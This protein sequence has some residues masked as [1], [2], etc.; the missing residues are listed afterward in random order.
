[1]VPLVVYLFSRNARIRPRM[2]WWP[3]IPFSLYNHASKPTYTH[4]AKALRL[5]FLLT[6]LLLAGGSGTASVNACLSR[7][8]TLAGYVVFALELLLLTA[9]QLWFF[10]WRRAALLPSSSRRVL[11][12][13]LAAVSAAGGAHRVRAAR[14]RAAGRAWERVEPADGVG[15]GVCADGAA[16]RV[17]GA[18]GLGARGARD[19]PRREVGG[20]VEGEDG[21]KKV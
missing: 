3:L 8:L 19:T 14:G 9:M 18:R 5:L 4:L 10:T 17:R 11:A 1:M 7:A 6:V 12:A 20:G 15:A 2:A 16:A 21:L 13:T